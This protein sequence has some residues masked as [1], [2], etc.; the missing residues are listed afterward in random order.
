MDLSVEG[1]VYLN[2]SL[3]NCCIGIEDGKISKI[4]KILKSEN[5]HY[6]GNNL[7]IPA[8]I[9]IH[10]HFRDPGMTHKEDFSTGSKSAA[11]GGISCVLDMP[12]TIP[13]TTSVQN[14]KEK[15]RMAGKKSYVDFG[16]YS[17]IT[18][19]NLNRISEIKKYCN[20]FKLYMGGSTNSMNFDNQ[21]L[22]LLQ[23]INFDNKP[24]L[25]HAEDKE[26]L[27]NNKFKEKNLMDHI[28]SRSSECEKKAIYDIIENLKGNNLKIHIC[29][30][31]SSEG[32]NLL[33]KFRNITCGVTPHHLFLNVENQKK[34]QSFFKTNPPIR[35]NFEREY[36]F[37]CLQNNVIDVIESDHAPH[38]FNEK[39][40][41]FN[42]APSG[43]P[44]V[45]TMIPIF[46]YLVH[47]GKL[48]IN[49]IVKL[50][51][52]KPSEILDIPK[53]KIEIGR[54]ADLMVVDLKKTCKI[55]Q[56]ELHYKCGWSPF[57]N[58]QAVFPKHVFIR[59]KHLISEGDL[60]LNKGF[61]KYIGE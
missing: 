2:G 58:F 14:L 53:G 44:G 52:E 32:I 6:F 23:N 60:I 10:V 54:D 8:G 16:I 55:N 25:I 47:K 45:E 3:N 7:I 48:S 59:G 27:D 21:N 40:I 50:F 34:N 38:T 13:Q 41:E 17:G 22:K 4:K 61:G 9:D 36:L 18:N 5:H 20:G 29:H 39:S 37:K 1:K 43:I 35:Q 51:C 26:C 42:E 30:I 57:E 28:R 11:F 49:K 24:I 15:I 56:D 12:N 19:N 46:L 31:S 33:K